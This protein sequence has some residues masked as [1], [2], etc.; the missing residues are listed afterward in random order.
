MVFR[1]VF[2]ILMFLSVLFL[3]WWVTVI[4]AMVFLSKFK[5]YEIIFWGVFADILYNAS[6]PSFLN[7]EYLFTIT[8]IV[9][10]I[11]SH[12]LKRRLMFYDV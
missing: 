6:V 4:V 2:N 7:I 11:I 8:F 9:L 3:P 12:Y 10:L 1:I 5:A